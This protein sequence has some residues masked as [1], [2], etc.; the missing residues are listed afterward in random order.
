MVHPARFE[1]GPLIKSQ[2]P[3]QL[4]HGYIVGGLN[5]GETNKMGGPDVL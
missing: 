3:I 1:L 2:I 5:P 4:S